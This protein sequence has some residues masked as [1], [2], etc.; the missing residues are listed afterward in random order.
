MVHAPDAG[1]TAREKGD[2]HP[3]GS[4]FSIGPMN[5]H[6]LRFTVGGAA[7]HRNAA[8]GPAMFGFEERQHTEGHQSD[9]DQDEKPRAEGFVREITQDRVDPLGLGRVVVR[10]RH[11]GGQPMPITIAPRAR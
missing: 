7:S 1:F 5:S 11:D 4:P 10:A 6:A 2:P 9:R 8:V 3:C